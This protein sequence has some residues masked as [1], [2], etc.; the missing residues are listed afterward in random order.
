MTSPVPSFS[1]QLSEFDM[2]RVYTEALLGGHP[3]VP[4]WLLLVLDVKGPPLG[5]PPSTT[6][7]TIIT[8]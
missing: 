4:G 3:A 6:T 1:G 7:I 5:N 8:V 2:I